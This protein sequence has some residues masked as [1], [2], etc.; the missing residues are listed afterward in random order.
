M[1]AWAT[2]YHV[3]WHWRNKR[4]FEDE[5]IMP[6]KLDRYIKYRVVQYKQSV[7]M[8]RKAMIKDNSTIH[9]RQKPLET[10]WKT[11]NT[12]GAILG[13]HKVGSKGLIRDHKGK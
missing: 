7:L 9:L 11:L 6:Q 12:D 10:P 3:L 2:A 8:S 13:N 5:F 4:I 1:E